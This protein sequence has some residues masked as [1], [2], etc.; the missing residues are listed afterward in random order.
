MRVTYSDYDELQRFCKKESFSLENV[1]Y[2]DTISVEVLADEDSGRELANYFPKA[3][4][5]V[6]GMRRVYRR[7]L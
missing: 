1:S 2:E 4:I 3:E 6:Y 5:E 7:E